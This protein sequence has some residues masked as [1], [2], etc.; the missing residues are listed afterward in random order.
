MFKFC[1][2]NIY[3]VL[4]SKKFRY[5]FTIEDLEFRKCNFTPNRQENETAI[6]EK[7]PDLIW[8]I[9]VY[10]NINYPCYFIIW[11]IYVYIKWTTIQCIY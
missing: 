11:I 7:I 3:V 5:C 9:Y 2:I 6:N 4:F 1:C 8:L 10:I